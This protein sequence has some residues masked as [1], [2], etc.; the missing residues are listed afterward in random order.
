VLTCE[1]AQSLRRARGL[2]RNKVV[3]G[4]RHAKMAL[5]FGD[6]RV[7]RLERAR[8]RVRRLSVLLGAREPLVA[9]LGLEPDLGDPPAD[10]R[11]LGALGRDAL[12]LRLELRAVCAQLLLELRKLRFAR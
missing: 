5:L 4:A 11:R 6:P 10:P 2:A 12:G 7:L 1:R 9:P 8:A 3:L